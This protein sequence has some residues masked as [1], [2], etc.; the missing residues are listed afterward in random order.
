[1]KELPVMIIIIVLKM[2][3]ILKLDVISLILSAKMKT[4][5]RKIPVMNLQENVNIISLIVMTT[6][7]AL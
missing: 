7:L 6:M 2:L 3:V 5:V 1:M 4:C